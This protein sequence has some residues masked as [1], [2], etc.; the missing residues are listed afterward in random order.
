MWKQNPVPYFAKLEYFPAV[1][2]KTDS[3]PADLRVKLLGRE[4]NHGFLGLINDKLNVCNKTVAR[5]DSGLSQIDHVTRL[6]NSLSK[7]LIISKIWS[8]DPTFFKCEKKIFIDLSVMHVQ[9]C[10]KKTLN[11]GVE[12]VQSW[13]FHF[14]L[15]SRI[16]YTEWMLCRVALWTQMVEQRINSEG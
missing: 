13:N 9:N 5:I 4:R 1:N 3:L 7:K 2:I 15:F 11:Y 16:Y 12:F 8:Y 14:S 6:K 10:K